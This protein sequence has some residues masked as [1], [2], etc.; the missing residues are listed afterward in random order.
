M[1][2][3]NFGR[4][5]LNLPRDRREA[6]K[7]IPPDRSSVK[8]FHNKLLDIFRR[9]MEFREALS[10]RKAVDDAGYFESIYQCAL[11]LYLVGD[12]AD[13]PLMWDA[14]HIDMDVGV[15]FDVQF[16]VGAGVA[17]TVAYLKTQGHLP[18]ASYLED[19]R[20]YKEFDNLERWERFRI[21]YFYKS[22]ATS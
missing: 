13:V 20:S 1:T 4:L 19:A 2:E 5:D 10:S 9:E 22:L 15:G 12:P 14:K 21:N 8:Q 16:L 18:I 11:L 6:L 3:I 17:E 7:A